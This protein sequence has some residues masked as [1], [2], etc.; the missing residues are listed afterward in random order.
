MTQQR[1]PSTPVAVT[2][3]DTTAEP[4][5]FVSEHSGGNLKLNSLVKIDSID[6]RDCNLTALM[7][8]ELRLF[9]LVVVKYS[10]YSFHIK[11]FAN[12]LQPTN[13]KFVNIK[14]SLLEVLGSI[15][16]DLTLRLL[17]DRKLTVNLFVIKD[18]AFATDIIL[19]KDFIS[20]QKLTVIFRL[21]DTK[22]KEKYDKASRP[23]RSITVKCK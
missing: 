12:K 5:A 20:N 21:R 15:K 14:D 8:W 11:Y 9:R 6:N 1:T 7:D 2:E 17:N 16:V 22:N 13:R 23:L 18:Q 19:G 4:I 3:D 10:V